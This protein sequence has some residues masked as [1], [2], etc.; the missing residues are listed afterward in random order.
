MRPARRLKA[1]VLVCYLTANAEVILTAE[2][3]RDQILVERGWDLERLKG[4]FFV[5]EPRR[6]HEAF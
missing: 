3:I 6:Q 5:G 4:T 2:G 1:L